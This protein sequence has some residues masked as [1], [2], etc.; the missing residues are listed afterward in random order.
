MK[1]LL[2]VIVVF[3]LSLSVKAQEKTDTVMDISMD[4]SMTQG[5]QK[6]CVMM[7]DGK[8]M[9]MKAG[10]KMM[11]KKDMS[12]PN[13]AMVMMDGT[14]KMQDGTTHLLTEGEGVLMDGTMKNIPMKKKMKEPM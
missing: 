13:G 2:M 4:S 8:M 6:D 11:M 7:K 5:K 3:M 1:H 14:M 12:F 10:K 9:Q